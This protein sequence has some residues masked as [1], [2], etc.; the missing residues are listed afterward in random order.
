[1]LVLKTDHELSAAQKDHIRAHFK[2]VT[3]EKVLILD[4]GMQLDTIKSRKVVRPYPSHLIRC[5]K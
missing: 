1:M 2:S 3:N 4:R 5:Y